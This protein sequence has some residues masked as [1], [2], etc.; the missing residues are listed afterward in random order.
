MGAFPETR[1]K[2]GER[3]ERG[4]AV[5]T[6][7]RSTAPALDSRPCSPYHHVDQTLA[8]GTE[9]G[10]P[11]MLL[12]CPGPR[13][14]YL[15]IGLHMNQS[16]GKLVEH[17]SSALAQPIV[18]TRRA[19][20]QRALGATG[21]VLLSACA[22]A[23]TPAGQAT[24]ALAG[25]KPSSATSAPAGASA[26]QAVVLKAV[27]S[28]E[29][30]ITFAQPL[31]RLMERIDKN[32]GGELKLELV[33]P[34]VVPPFEA[35]TATSRGVADF[36]HTTPAFYA[37]NLPEA[38]ALHFATGSCEKYRKAGALEVLDQVHRAKTNTIF[39]G[40]GGG[41][42][43]FVF[44]T[45]DPVTSLD[46]F[47]GKKFRTTGLY[48]PILNA[49]GASPV[50][51]PPQEVYTALERR[52]ADGVAW[53]ENG[54]LERKLHE[55]VKYMIKPAWFEVRLSELI[56]VDSWNKLPPHLQKAL[57]ETVLELEPESDQFF[58]DLT[59]KEQADLQKAGMQI[60]TLPEPEADKLLKLVDD[61][62]W[63]KIEQDSPEWGGKLRAS[64]TKARA[65]A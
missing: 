5:R 49:L 10:Q 26:K 47:Q 61:S 48:T 65:A 7:G 17:L 31:L 43:G 6:P 34:E 13:G 53:P 9:T 22:P 29:R 19:F 62:T 23:A 42:A 14:N 24:P 57:Q 11:K 51:I 12:L 36:A 37:T 35:V 38:N 20:L 33:G 50:E 3:R 56:N 16:E 58:R 54:I 4:P 64:F 46:Y 44:L 55:V 25:A 40:C 21:V 45:R 59:L 27:S 15:R 41:G 8:P 1:V 2:G 39:L 30:N 32:T 52:V 18:P 63:A 60:V 28:W